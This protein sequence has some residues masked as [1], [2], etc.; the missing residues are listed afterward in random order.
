MQNEKIQRLTA[1]LNQEGCFKLIVVNEKLNKYKVMCL[2]C[3]EAIK[4]YKSS[5]FALVY[6]HMKTSE[7]V[8]NFKWFNE[9]KLRTRT[10]VKQSNN[11]VNGQNLEL[12]IK[13]RQAEIEL[14]E[15]KSKVVNLKQEKMNQEA[16]IDD[17]KAKITK[18]NSQLDIGIEKYDLL[19]EL[20]QLKNEKLQLSTRLL[21]LKA[22]LK[23]LD[24]NSNK[25]IKEFDLIYENLQC[26]YE[27]AKYEN[28]INS[29]KQK[30]NLNLKKNDLNAFK[31][32]LLSKMNDFKNKN[33]LMNS[34]S[35][36]PKI[37]DVSSVNSTNI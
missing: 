37:I 14:E 10:T 2:A 18:S 7:H 20:Q 36:L 23:S 30:L 6:A 19:K 21:Q 13:I 28:L 9:E 31:L 3:G 5:S 22:D 1:K 35:W 32:S 24:N 34:R 4:C 11:Q 15:I 27:I 17:L 8:E 25:K 33:H 29:V 12:Q 16:I 26:T